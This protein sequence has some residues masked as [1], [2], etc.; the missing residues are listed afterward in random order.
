MGLRPRTQDMSAALANGLGGLARVAMAGGVV[1]GGIQAS[2]YDVDVGHRIVMY[3]RFEGVE[4]RVRGEGTGFLIPW[5]Q[6]PFH[7]DV[8]VTPREYP[9]QTGTK[10]LQTVKITLRVLVRPVEE[11]LPT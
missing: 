10:D 1:L 9:T 11:K 4:S 5:V 6:Q 3:N 8:R 7:Y 2:L